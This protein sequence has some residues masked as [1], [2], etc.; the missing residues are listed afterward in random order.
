MEKPISEIINEQANGRWLDIFSALSNR[1]QDAVERI[2]NHV[3]CPR[4]IGGENSYRLFKDAPVT[5][6]SISN[7]AGGLPSGIQTL[8]WVNDWDYKTTLRELCAYF[9]IGNKYSYVTK[10]ELPKKVLYV[11]TELSDEVLARRRKYLRDTYKGS[12]S[13]TDNRSTLAIKYF[14]NRG[15]LLTKEDVS[16][17][18]SDIRFHPNLKFWHEKKCL[19]AYPCILC[20]VKD[21]NGIAVTL[22]KTYLDYQGNKLN[23]SQFPYEKEP[24]NAKQIM[25]PCSKNTIGGCCIQLFGQNKRNPEQLSIAEGLETAL[26]VYVGAGEPCWVGISASWMRKFQPSYN[27]KC[28]I[29]WA[30][31]DRTKVSEKMAEFLTEKLTKENKNLDII[32]LIPN[33]VLK[34]NQKGYDWNDYLTEFGLIDFNVM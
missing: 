15:I 26:S 1:L 9:Q 16:E 33:I 5:G 18:S 13:L 31:L 19:G 4:G 21:A 17:L 22:H 12:H 25:P 30:D 32:T 6:G 28:L 27:T 23:V 24:A 10:R 11:E 34:E 8:M 3:P 14:Q 20:I 7:Q 2:P 29:I